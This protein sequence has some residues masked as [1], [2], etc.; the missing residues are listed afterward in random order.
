MIA[1]R[2][3]ACRATHGTIIHHHYVGG[4]CTQLLNYVT[5]DTN[6]VAYTACQVYMCDRLLQTFVSNE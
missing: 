4:M 6:I 1:Q 5:T 2:C 3:L